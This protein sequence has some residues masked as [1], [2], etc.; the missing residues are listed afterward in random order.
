M[1]TI[2]P[3]TE[4]QRA[5]FAAEEPRYPLKRLIHPADVAELVL[6]P[7]AAAPAPAK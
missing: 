1:V 2:R 5:I 4:R 3:A 7:F 6:V